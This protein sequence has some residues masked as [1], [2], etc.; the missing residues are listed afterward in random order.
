MDLGLEGK[1]AWVLGASGGL[2][3]ATARALADEGAHV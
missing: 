3:R 2:G 1:V